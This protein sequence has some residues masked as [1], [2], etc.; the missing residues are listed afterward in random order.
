MLR[1][2]STL[3]VAVTAGTRRLCGRP[4]DPREQL[5]VTYL[6]CRRVD[7]RGGVAVGCNFCHAV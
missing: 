6:P 4:D 7:A 3:A 1:D 5:V 2:L